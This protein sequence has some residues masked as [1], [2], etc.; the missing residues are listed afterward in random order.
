[1]K[2][3]IFHLPYKLDQNGKGARMVRPAKMIQAFKD[4]GYDVFVIEGWSSERRKKIA[5]AKRNILNGVKYDFIYSESNTSPMLLNDPHHMPTHPFL[6]FGF[7]RFASKHG[8]KTGLFYCDIYWKFDNYGEGLPSWKRISALYNYRYDVTQYKKTLAAFY[9]PGMKVLNYLDEPK[10]R[11]IAKELPPGADNIR[12]ERGKRIIRDFHELP[13]TVFYV[14]GLG[15]HYRI[16]ELVKA[17][18]ETDDT[19]LIICC[20]REEWEKEKTAFEPYLNEKTEVIHKSSHELEPY[21]D[22]ADICSLLF[23]NSEYMGMAQPVK[24]YEYLAHEMPVIST[25]GTDI[26][27]FVEK[28]GIGWNIDY[29]A[30]A[31][32]KVLNTV[33][34]NPEVL[35]K[36]RD[37]CRRTKADNLW[38]VRAKTVASDLK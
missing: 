21:Y 12:A 9:V 34:S 14:G 11:A 17:I 2:K 1:M 5:Q 7:F 16:S 8:I 26:G 38:T 27:T 31:I 29:D 15:N 24:A 22:Q 37:N 25:K 35:E 32:A 13:L 6:D 28:N 3:C 33:K 30:D 23:M 18:Y 10:L 36:I 4:I 20:R 19:R